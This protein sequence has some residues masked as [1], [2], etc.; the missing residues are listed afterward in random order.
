MQLNAK[1][2]KQ[3][4]RLIIQ[5]KTFTE[6]YQKNMLEKC[7]FLCKKSQSLKF[8]PTTKRCLI[9]YSIL[10]NKILATHKFEDLSGF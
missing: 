10:F 3:A 4:L 5:C 9:K 6:T 8:D 2:L 1:P 7:Q